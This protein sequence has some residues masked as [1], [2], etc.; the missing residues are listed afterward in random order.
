MSKAAEVWKAVCEEV[1][2][3]MTL[4]RG[5]AP[6]VIRTYNAQTAYSAVTEQRI[7]VVLTSQ[8]REQTS[9]RSI[10]DVYEFSV[11]VLEP[12]TERDLSA[13]MEH[14]DSLLEIIP[15]LADHFS[16]K[17]LERNGIEMIFTEQAVTIG[18]RP[19]ELDELIDQQIFSFE[20]G[21]TVRV[22]RSTV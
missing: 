11:L 17:R 13:Q 14:L 7:L 9:S 5:E 12:F 22:A 20:M 8:S 4:A 3:A 1:G 10:W 15:D 21:L 19:Y 6:E 16:M 18:N 2:V